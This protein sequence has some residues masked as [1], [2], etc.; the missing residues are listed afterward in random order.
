MEAT[1]I[2]DE[3]RRMFGGKVTGFS[4]REERAHENKHLKAY[5]AGRPYF[6]NGRDNDGNRVVFRTLEFW[7]TDAEYQDFLATE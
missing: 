2:L 5:L 1:T 7:V 3:K 4:S 6:F